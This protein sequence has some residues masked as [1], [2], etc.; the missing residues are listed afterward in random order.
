M[1]TIKQRGQLARL[2]ADVQSQKPPHGELA[3]KLRCACG[4][5]L[6]FNIQS[7]G[8]SRGHCAAGCGVRWTQ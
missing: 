1:P 2:R 6:H 7:T 8:L 3:G 4:A 5:T